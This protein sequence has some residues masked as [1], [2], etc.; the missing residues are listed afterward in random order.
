MFLLQWFLRSRTRR[1][2]RQRVRSCRPE[3]ERLEDRVQPSATA[4]AVESIDGTGNNLA[5]A[6]WGS[7]GAD[8]LRIAPAAYTDGI[9]TPAGADRPSARVISNTIADQGSADIVSDRQMS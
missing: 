9:S 7:A 4:G 3:V 2:L 6:D 1:E 8:L 5:H